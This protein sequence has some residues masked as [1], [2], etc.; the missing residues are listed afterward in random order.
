MYSAPRSHCFGQNPSL[1]WTE[2]AVL[3]TQATPFAR[4]L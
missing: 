4:T 1:S 2:P 3:V